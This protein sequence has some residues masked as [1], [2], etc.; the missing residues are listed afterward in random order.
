MIPETKELF[1]SH[2]P[3]L[4]VLMSMG[5]TYLPPKE[6]IKQN[7]KSSSNYLLQPIS[8]WGQPDGF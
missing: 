3:A 2:I 1:S 6:K 8:M 7:T 5:Y 4:Q